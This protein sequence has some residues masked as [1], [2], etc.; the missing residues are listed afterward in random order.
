MSEAKYLRD[1]DVLAITNVPLTVAQQF[2][3]RFKQ[4]GEFLLPY[5]VHVKHGSKGARRHR[6]R[7]LH[8]GNGGETPY[9]KLRSARVY[10]TPA[11]E[12]R[13]DFANKE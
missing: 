12:R 4:Y 9:I 1:E 3:Q 6:V 11:Q 7:I 13:C 10:L 8:Y 2:R 5:V